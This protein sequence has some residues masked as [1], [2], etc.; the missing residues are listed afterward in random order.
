MFSNIGSV[1]KEDRGKVGKAMNHIKNFAQQRFEEA[2]QKLNQK[3]VTAKATE[4]ITLPAAPLPSGSY[5]PLT[6]TLEEMKHIFYRLGFN[7]ADGPEIEDDFHNFTALNFP[8]NHPARDEQDTFFIKKYEDAN[9]N[10]LV[11]RT[12]TSPVQIRLMKEKKPPI[13]AI[14]PGRVYRNEAVTPKSYFLFHQVEA[15]YVDTDVSVADLKATLISFAQMMFGSEVKYR[16]RPGFF[17]FTEPSLE[18]DIWWETKDGGGKWLEILGSGMVDPNVFKS[19]DLD[20]E[21]Y[22]GFA[23]GMGVERIAMLRHGIDDIRLFYN[24]DNRFLKQFN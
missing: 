17:P 11:L 19:V 22:T 9:K 8:P 4:D 21:K 13:R 6:Q 18:M 1:P 23:W 24:N 15:L 12:H 14:M 20:P 7:I 16:I 5:H 3:N 10:D 2:E